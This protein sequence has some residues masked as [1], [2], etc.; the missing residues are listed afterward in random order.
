MAISGCYSLLLGLFTLKAVLR[1]DL[2]SLVQRR[3]LLSSLDFSRVDIVGMNNEELER[4]I[5][6]AVSD[7]EFEKAEM[8]SRV[9]LQK[10]ESED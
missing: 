7:L 2:D 10:I 3:V 1:G 5:E 4:L 9:L 6:E 8:I